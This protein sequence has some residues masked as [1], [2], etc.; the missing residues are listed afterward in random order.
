MNISKEEISR[1]INEAINGLGAEKIYL[2]SLRFVDLEA[3]EA[4]HNISRTDLCAT[5]AVAGFAVGIDFALNN[6]EITDDGKGE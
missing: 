3:M 4:E 2:D 1:L 5:F 6:L